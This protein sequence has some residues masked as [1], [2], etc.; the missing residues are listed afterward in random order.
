MELSSIEFRAMNHPLRRAV[1]RWYEW[2]IMR[3]MG[4]EPEGKDLIEIGCGSGYAASLIARCGP[5]RYVGI[6]LM[7]Q[8]VELA[9]ARGLARCDFR[10]GDVS[11][12]SA[13]ADESFDFAVDFGILH[14]VPA[15]PRA[16]AECARVLRTGGLLV[17]EEPEGE[18][19]RRFD[20][21]FHWGHPDEAGFSSGELEGELSAHGLRVT[22]S[23]RAVGFFWLA[24]AKGEGS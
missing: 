24:A 5:R 20:R 17:V 10:V 13:F 18:V 8:Q 7:P 1:Q 15:W 4:L 23:H 21:R 22:R 14:H 16:L 11:D 9:R 2:P 6:D 19:L 12:L 3:R